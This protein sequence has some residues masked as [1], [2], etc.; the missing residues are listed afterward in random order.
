MNFLDY[1]FYRMKWWNTKVVLDFSPFLSAVII[2]AVFQ[3]F[4]ILFVFNVIKYN[5]GISVNFVERYYLLLPVIFFV[6]NFFYYR[7][8]QR[9]AKIDAWV[10]DMPLKRKKWYDFFVVLYFVL[11]LFLLIWIGYLIRLTHL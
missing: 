7:L 5:W 9:Q 11:S 10:L 2:M 4:N 3:G 6:W 8:P 1:L